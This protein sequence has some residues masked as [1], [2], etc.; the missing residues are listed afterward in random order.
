MER[1]PFYEGNAYCLEVVAAYAAAGGGTTDAARLLGLAWALRDV[2]GTRSW[3]LLRPMS[4]RI[5]D[6]VQSASD[7]QSFD[8][9]FGEGRTLDP[10]TGAALCRAA[11]DVPVAAAKQT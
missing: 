10:R 11:L 8:A 6:K 4:R 2:L 7:A 1:Q 5:H 9:A 3:A